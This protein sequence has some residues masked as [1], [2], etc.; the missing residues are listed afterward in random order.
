MMKWL[1]SA[2]MGEHPGNMAALASRR[3]ERRPVDARHVAAQPLTHMWT[4]R[5]AR[6]ASAA[7]TGLSACRPAA[8]ETWLGTQRAAT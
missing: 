2:A 3:R 8:R 6:D 4:Q 5:R 7:K 1:R